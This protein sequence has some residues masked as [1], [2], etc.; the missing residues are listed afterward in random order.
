MTTEFM[1][2]LQGSPDAFRSVLPDAS[3][4]RL[5]SASGPWRF[6]TETIETASTVLSPGARRGESISICLL[7]DPSANASWFRVPDLYKV[8]GDADSYVIGVNQ[9]L[10]QTLELVTY[11]VFG[12]G[13]ERDEEALRF[14]GG[15][16]ER[17]AQRVASRVG[18]FLE[19]G[20]PFGFEE[21]EQ[22]NSR[23]AALVQALV[24]DALQFSVLH[25]VS[26]WLL[27]HDRGKHLLRNRLVDL[28]IATFSI[29][30]EHQADRL[31]MRLHSSIR[32]EPAQQFPGME[33]AGPALL[34]GV[35]GLFER[36]TRYQ[37]AFDTPHAHPPAYERLYRLRV[38]VSAGGG[39][40]YWPVPA[41]EG[42]RLARLDLSANPQAIAFA[43]VKRP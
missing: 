29:G 28:Q 1:S 25:E 35:L 43:E 26:H 15:M 18:A 27:M 20:F 38:E 31:A 16:V 22:P 12:E 39:H 42:F 33:F 6:G 37:A 13:Q 8:P 23:R 36:Y 10:I 34:F 4:V 19:L 21:T 17:A 2:F 7:N 3:L 40:Q 11:D 30:E 24:A 5:R 14:D 41:A 32:R 9:G